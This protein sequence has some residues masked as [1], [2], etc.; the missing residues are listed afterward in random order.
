[1]ETNKNT[2]I[3]NRWCSKKEKKIPNRCICAC[4][5]LLFQYHF[6]SHYTMCQKSP[7]WLHWLNKW[8]FNSTT[9]LMMLL[10]K[11]IL[12]MWDLYFL[13]QNEINTKWVYILLQCSSSFFPLKRNNFKYIMLLFLIINFIIIVIILKHNFIKI[14]F[15][16]N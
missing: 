11:N 15:Y 5:C 4:V 2:I 3:P 9:L 13:S 1:M 16:F 10:L 12:P 7:I 14:W 6:H 8:I